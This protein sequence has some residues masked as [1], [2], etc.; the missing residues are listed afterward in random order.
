MVMAF[1]SR[2]YQARDLFSGSSIAEVLPGH[3]PHRISK[4]ITLALW[5][6]LL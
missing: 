5:A 4:E 1:E 2:D 6:Y 3:S